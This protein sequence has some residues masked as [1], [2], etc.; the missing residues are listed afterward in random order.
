MRKN[1][2]IDEATLTKLKII[3]AFEDVSVKALM[4]KAVSFFVSHKEKERLDA[5]SEEEKEDI[6]LLLLMQQVD[7]NDTVSEEDFFKALEEE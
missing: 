4:E 7:L 6:G 5:L 1:I 3:A 2:D